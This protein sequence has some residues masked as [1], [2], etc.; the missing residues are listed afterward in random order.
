MSLLSIRTDN[1]P[2]AAAT[3]GAPEEFVPA[4]GA[5]IALFLVGDPS[6]RSDLSP[7]G[8]RPQDDLFRNGYG[9]LVDQR[10]GKI[11]AFMAAL[12]MFLLRTAPDGTPG[13]VDE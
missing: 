7:V 6:F 10:A 5:P 4:L 12:V 11:G 2:A 1:G 8:D 13:A 3:L 9:E